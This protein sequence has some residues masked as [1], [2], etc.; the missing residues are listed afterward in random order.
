MKNE[1]SAAAHGIVDSWGHTFHMNIEE[2]M[3]YGGVLAQRISN[4][5]TKRRVLFAS[6][7]W[8]NVIA[9]LR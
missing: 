2:L 1:W 7:E 5:L 6:Q 4:V 3:I 9:E 8:Q